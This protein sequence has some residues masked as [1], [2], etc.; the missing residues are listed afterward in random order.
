MLL[1]PLRVAV[2]G[3]GLGVN[4]LFGGNELNPQQESFLSVRTETGFKA[5]R[6]SADDGVYRDVWGFPYIVILDLDYDGKVR[7]PFFGPANPSEREFLNTSVAVFSLGADGQVD[8]TKAPTG[9]G[10]K[11]TVNADNIYSWK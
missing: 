9:Q 8:F 11:G 7:N 4:A 1:E 10:A 5:D 2:L 3:L 6:V